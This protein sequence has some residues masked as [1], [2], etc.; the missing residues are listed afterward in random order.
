LRVV[1]ERKS[2]RMEIKSTYEERNDRPT[3][4]TI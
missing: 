2:F 4:E 1:C 3:Q